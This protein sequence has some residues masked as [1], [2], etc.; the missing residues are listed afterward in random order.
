MNAK[1]IGRYVLAMVAAF[2][3][4]RDLPAAG[5]SNSKLSA[6]LIITYTAGSSNIVAGHPQVL[7]ILDVGSDM[8]KAVR[9]YKAGTPNGKVVLRVYSPKTYNLTND[10]TASASDYWTT[11]LQPALNS[12]SASDRAL[13]DYLEGPNEGDTPTLGSP[14]GY[15]LQGSQ[16]INQFWTNLTP[17]IVSNGLKPCIGSIAVGNPGGSTTQIQSYLDAF[18]P[19]LRQSHSV[20]GAWSYHAYTIQYSTDTNVEIYYS[21][22]YRQFYSYFAQAYPNLTNMPMILTEGGVDQNGTPATS[23]WQARGPA[24]YYQRWLNWFDNQMSQDPYIVGCTLFEN[25]N[26]S[27]WPSFDLE[28]ICNWF[29]NYLTNPTGPP[30]PPSGVSASIGNSEITVTWTNAP[31]NP[32]SFNIKRSQT[33]GGP[34][35][36]IA[37]NLTT[38][39]TNYSFVDASVTNGGVYYYVVSAVNAF[40]EGSNSAEVTPPVIVPSKINCGGPAAAPFISDIYFS[41]GQT[42]AVTNSINTNGL[43]NPAPVAVYQSQRYQNLT[44]ALPYLAT[45]ASYKVRL[46]F[47]EIYWTAPGQRVF[48]VFLN[49]AQVL[50]NFDI[51]A[52]A[53]GSFKGNIQEFNAIADSSG[54]ISVQLVTV[55]DN[56]SINGLELVANPTNVLP[57]APTGLAATVST[58]I[59]SLNWL[60]P[61]SAT[62]FNIR[63]STTNGGPYSV[64]ASN[65]TSA[66]FNDYSFTPG[67]TYYYVVTGQ[68]ALGE[69]PFSAQVTAAPT[70]GLPDLVVTSV[71][72]TPNP[73]HAGDSVLFS[74]TVKN[75]GSAS[76]PNGT[77]LGVGFSIDGGASY[78][79]SGYYTSALSPGS[80]VVLN[81]SGG[82]SP[83]GYWPATVGA[84]TVVA[85]VDD[86]NRIQESNEGNNLYTLNYSVLSVPPP[87]FFAVTTS[88]AAINLQ[89]SSYP[90]K[91]YQVQYKTNLADLAWSALPV[92]YTAGTTNVSASDTN[93]GS[94]NRFY[95]VQQ[96]N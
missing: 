20:G 86:V 38:G 47:A 59:V 87:Q 52:A 49:G 58:G 13:I 14:P 30:P 27:G 4:V 44:Y 81:A 18:V 63:R 40:G 94:A 90:G 96:L 93:S 64:I 15:E 37:S 60:A 50:T 73:A 70:A 7:K 69:G 9:D 34:Y 1:A 12:L 24:D 89:F 56:A 25:G 80:S 2:A 51:F 48:N 61:A 28:P 35:A 43:V 82:G 8:I 92:T 95:R 91:Q 5:L 41:A 32:C 55:T 16:W 42:Y 54:F 68:D 76:T 45:N 17:M 23:G 57:A 39:V 3:L 26:P 85:N 84:H 62:G 75:Q 78:P 31:V 65:L 77:V 11:V 83:G 66:T 6:H 79:Y 29:Y 71:T 67:T 33:S 74:A 36:V 19:A 22:R 88:G 72:Y 21:L 53:G 10:P 46:H